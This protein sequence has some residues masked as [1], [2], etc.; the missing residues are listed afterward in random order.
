MLA[1]QCD[2]VFFQARF[3][4]EGLVVL[5]FASSSWPCQTQEHDSH[6]FLMNYPRC[7]EACGPTPRSSTAALSDFIRRPHSGWSQWCKGSIKEAKAPWR[8]GSTL[9][10]AT[11][12]LGKKLIVIVAAGRRGNP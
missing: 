6:T 7:G 12:L 4:T 1:L 9:V 2:A 5:V 3:L 11:M 8:C 10:I